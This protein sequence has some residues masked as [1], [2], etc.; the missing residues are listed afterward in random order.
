MGLWRRARPPP[1]AAPCAARRA[2]GEAAG[3][4]LLIPSI[5]FAPVRVGLLAAAK[6][7]GRNKW[8]RADD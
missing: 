5:W 3:F 8:D 1:P 4:N 6:T 7:D 2:A